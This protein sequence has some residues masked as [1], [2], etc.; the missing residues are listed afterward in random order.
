MPPIAE[1][2]VVSDIPS[3]PRQYT[4]PDRIRLNVGTTLQSPCFWVIVGSVS[5]LAAIYL[6][7]QILRGK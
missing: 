1:T 7:R 2:E 6:F 4:C 5:T 3:A